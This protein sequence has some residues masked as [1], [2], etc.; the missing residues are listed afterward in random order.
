MVAKLASA[1]CPSMAVPAA[2]VSLCRSCAWVS[3]FRASA[4]KRSPAGEG[5]TPCA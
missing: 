3:R 5:L 1:S 4:R 2:A